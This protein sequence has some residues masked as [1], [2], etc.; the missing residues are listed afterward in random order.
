LVDLSSGAR[1]MSNDSTA[2]G[3]VHEGWNHLQSQRPLAAWGSW[4]R[5]FKAEPDS[6]AAKQALATL[7]SASDL[8]VAARA[9]YR[10]RQPVDSER[11]AVWD[12][13][14]EGRSDS[15][16][17]ATADLFGALAAG[18]PSDAA[19]WYNR[20]LALAWLGHNTEAVACLDRV[21]N[22]EAEHAFDQA[23]DAW[24]L[25]E[26]L[27]HGA[28]AESLADDLRYS[29]TIPWTPGDTGWLR[30]E[31]AELHPVSPPQL[32][33]ALEHKSREIEVFEWLDRPSDGVAALQLS[34][35]RL[36]KVLASIYAGQQSL[37]LSSP[38]RETLEVVEE[39][40]LPLL[41]DRVR[42]IRREAVPLPLPF[43]DAAAWTFRVP[44]GVEPEQA[45][46]LRRESIEHYMENEW[47]HCR[48]HG[49]GG[50]SPLEAAREGSAIARARLTAVVRLREQLGSRPAAVML[51]QGYPF[52]RL[53][54]RLGLDL[55]YPS[56]VDRRELASASAEELDEL[57]TSDLDQ[58]RLVEAVESAAGLRDDARTARFAALLIARQPA[59]TVRFDLTAAVAAL[60]RLAMAQGD[61][62]T[63]I[64]WIERAKP[65]ADREQARALDVWRAEI[66]ARA[67]QPEEALRVYR[68][69]INAG[70]ATAGLALDAAL[71]M[72]DNGHEHEAQSLLVTARELAQQAGR[73]SVERRA[74]R[75]LERLA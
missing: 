46:E 61:H 43:L 18:D 60:V 15:D 72:L 7:E 26:V 69:L 6:A 40:L 3:L 11:R 56:S 22:L 75:M 28:G 66:L 54:R 9:T 30:D 29:F 42:S 55:V 45:D 70:S 12:R 33:G 41:D 58:A 14:F 13:A 23:V 4:Q 24:T 20:A 67:H 36:P 27:R 53:R 65:I 10:F 35:A 2:S 49:L 39:R 64:R 1:T 34:S 25:A 8:P 57:G 50:R 74:E 37:R 63:A 52:D 5:A 44:V 62:G 17:A 71:T 31:F 68:E 38:R 32:S 21:V 73:R 59:H 16:L 47:I 48:R 51:Y 19:A